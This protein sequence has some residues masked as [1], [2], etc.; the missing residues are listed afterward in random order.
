MPPRRRPTRRAAGVTRI[1]FSS[2]ESERARTI[3]P[4]ARGTGL[5][6]ET[7]LEGEKDG[8]PASRGIKGTGRRMERGARNKSR[9]RNRKKKTF[10]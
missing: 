7:G 2:R 10:S 3:W 5:E 1:A 4:R 9:D 6:R 8:E